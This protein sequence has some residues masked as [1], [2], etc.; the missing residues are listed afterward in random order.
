MVDYTNNDTPYESIST[1]QNF[2]TFGNY[3]YR[4]AEQYAASFTR[5]DSIQST[6]DAIDLCV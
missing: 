4:V 2:D 1:L 3:K 6:D 5:I